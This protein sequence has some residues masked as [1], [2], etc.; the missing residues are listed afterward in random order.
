[1]RVGR[2]MLEMFVYVEAAKLWWRV[3]RVILILGL[4]LCLLGVKP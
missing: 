1:M 2:E 4:G 3:A